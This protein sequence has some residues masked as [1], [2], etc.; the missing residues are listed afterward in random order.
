MY[1]GSKANPIEYIEAN[2]AIDKEAQTK[3]TI[4]K[5]LSHLS[6]NKAIAIKMDTAA[7]PTKTNPD[8]G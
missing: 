8:N 5:K 4:F 7:L 6:L 2:K 3:D 1:F